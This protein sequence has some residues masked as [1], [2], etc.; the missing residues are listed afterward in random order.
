MCHSILFRPVEFP[1]T[2]QL[3]VWLGFL[4]VNWLFLGAYL[5]IFSFCST[6]DNLIMMREDGFWSSCSVFSALPLYL[7]F[8]PSLFGGFLIYYLI[9]YIFQPS[10]CLMPPG[11]PIIL[12]FGLLMAS[13]NS[14]MFFLAFLF[15]LSVWAFLHVVSSCSEIPSSTSL[16]LLLKLSIEF[17]IFCIV[18]LICNNPVYFGSVLLFPFVAFLKFLYVLLILKESYNTF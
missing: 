9:K 11:T 6:K 18:F 15:Q 17:L 8:P 7:V 5:G 14:Y 4:Y 2:D 1:L 13:L 10:F 16:I 12:M 3:G